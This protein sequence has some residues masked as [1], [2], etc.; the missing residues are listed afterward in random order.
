M[1]HV[2]QISSEDFSP[3][4]KGKLRKVEDDSNLLD[5]YS[6]AVV[7]S[8]EKVSAAVVNI[9]VKK[10]TRS[11]SGSDAALN[12]GRRYHCHKSIPRNIT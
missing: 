5:A 8:T 6:Q 4:S 9:K 7:S 10:K 12:P 11:G 2:R 1:T 3:Q